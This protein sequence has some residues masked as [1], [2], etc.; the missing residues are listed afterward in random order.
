VLSNPNITV[1]FKTRLIEIQGE[2]KVSAAILAADGADSGGEARYEEAIDAVFIFA[3]SLP[4]TELVQNLGLTFDSSGYVI[5]D[6][7]MASAVPGLFAA[8]DVCSSPFRQVVVAAGEG[9]VAAH[10]AAQYLDN[11]RGEAYY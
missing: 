5:T 2:N 7:R 1:R 6:Q 8:G 11:L 10:C 4:R 3:G 9:A